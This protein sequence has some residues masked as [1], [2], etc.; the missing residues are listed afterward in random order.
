MTLKC[1]LCN[2]TEFEKEDGMFVCGSCGTK[3]PL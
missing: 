3:Y 1:E 2:C